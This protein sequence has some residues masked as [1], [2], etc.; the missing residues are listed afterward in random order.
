MRFAQDEIKA[1]QAKAGGQEEAAFFITED[2]T[3]QDGMGDPAEG[4]EQIQEEKS[5]GSEA[6]ENQGESQDKLAIEAA[7]E[8]GE[9]QQDAG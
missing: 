4:V 1:M 2:V 6:G 3:A 7:P 9:K 8:D 5:Y